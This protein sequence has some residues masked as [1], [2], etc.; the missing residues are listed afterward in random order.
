MT[1]TTKGKYLLISWAILAFSTNGFSSIWGENKIHTNYT[2][3]LVSC[4][5]NHYRRLSHLSIAL[6]AKIY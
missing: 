3:S 2:A 4:K 6:T 1:T 5:V